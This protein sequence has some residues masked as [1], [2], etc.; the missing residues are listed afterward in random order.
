MKTVVNKLMEELSNEQLPLYDAFKVGLNQSSD[1]D[2]IIRVNFVE[3]TTAHITLEDG[4]DASAYV[5]PTTVIGSSNDYVQIRILQGGVTLKITN[6]YGLTYYDN[7]A[8][9]GYVGTINPSLMF[10]ADKVTFFGNHD[11]NDRSSIISMAKFIKA[12]N[13]QLS[14]SKISGSLND[15]AEAQIAN[16]RD[17]TTDPSVVIRTS[18]QITY[19]NGTTTVY[20]PN[21]T[22]IC[23]VYIEGGYQLR[24]TDATG[25]ILYDSTQN[26]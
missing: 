24:D 10:G 5:S 8:G 12:T 25:T 16:G 11:A 19:W 7:V 17:Y 3:G 15:F 13:I 1:S 18:S 4:G 21:N 6:M 22:Y 23:I 26:T 20:C 14:Y 2:K 9:G